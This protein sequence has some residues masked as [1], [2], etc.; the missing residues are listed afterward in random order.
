M[1]STVSWQYTLRSVMFNTPA[2]TKMAALQMGS[3][4]IWLV[5]LLDTL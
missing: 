1:N 3:A 2:E 5:N 4:Y